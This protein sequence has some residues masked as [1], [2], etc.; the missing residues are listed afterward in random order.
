MAT[1]ASLAA[2]PETLALGAYIMDLGTSFLMFS[3]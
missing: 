3:T 2:H 1:G